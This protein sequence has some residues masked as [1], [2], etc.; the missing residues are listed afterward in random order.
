MSLCVFWLTNQGRRVR[1]HPRHCFLWFSLQQ[2]RLAAPVAASSQLTS[3]V[4]PAIPTGSLPA[5]FKV[6]LVHQVWVNSHLCRK[7][8][9]SALQGL[10][11]CFLSVQNQ[12][13]AWLKSWTSVLQCHH[14]TEQV[15]AGSLSNQEKSLHTAPISSCGTPRPASTASTAHTSAL[16]K[17]FLPQSRKICCQGLNSVW[18]ECCFVSEPEISDKTE[19]ELSERRALFVFFSQTCSDIAFLSAN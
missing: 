18:K 1:S 14:S 12:T 15:G 10:H 5:A 4:S 19:H 3:G 16:H 17:P 9:A 13:A 11:F 8:W 7:T 2:A 6:C